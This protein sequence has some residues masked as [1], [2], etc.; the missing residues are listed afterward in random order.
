[1]GIRI[2]RL[3]LINILIAV[4]ITVEAPAVSINE[5]KGAY[6]LG[7]L[8]YITWN[9]EQSIDEFRIGMAGDS[10]ELYREL[11]GAVKSHKVKGKRITVVQ[12]GNL[13]EM[14]GFHLL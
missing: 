14:P 11:L 6:M 4:V 9:N 5:I 8:N 10:T 7:F 12:T 2:K 13:K 3:L 1:M